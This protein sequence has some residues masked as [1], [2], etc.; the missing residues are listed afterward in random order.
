VYVPGRREEDILGQIWMRIAQGSRFR[1]MVTR[2][3]K[4]T[5]LVYFDSEV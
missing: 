4:S 3:N 5:D 2:V 1:H